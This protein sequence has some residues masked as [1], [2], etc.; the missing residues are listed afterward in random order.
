MLA[1]ANGGSVP[2]RHVS[3]GAPAFGT[4][5]AQGGKVVYTPSAATFA[6]AFTYVVSD[7]EATAEGRVAIRAVQAITPV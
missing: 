3:V 2:A 5:A 6:D 4:A 7:G 1:S